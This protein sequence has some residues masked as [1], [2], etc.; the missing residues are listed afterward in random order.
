MS[1]HTIVLELL[2]LCLLLVVLMYEMG[3]ATGREECR[4]AIEGSC[5]LADA[6]AHSGVRAS[7]S[8]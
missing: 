2:I 3:V 5:R 7:T 8:G 1:P 6:G 4:W